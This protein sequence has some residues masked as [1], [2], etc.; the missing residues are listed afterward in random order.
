MATEAGLSAAQVVKSGWYKSLARF[1]HPN[2]RQAVWQMVNSFVPYLGLW[3][4][5]VV[6]VQ[7]GQGWLWFLPLL[8]LAAAGWQLRLFIIFH[9]C[10]HSSFFGSA[11]A[12]RIVG[13]VTGIVNFTPFEDWRH[14]HLVHHA[15][16][17]D[18]DLRGTGDVWTMTVAEYQ[19]AP[20][21]KR[22]AYRLFRT[23]FV[24]FV[25]GPTVVFMLLQRFPRKGIS[26]RE[27]FSVL[28]TDAAVL[29]MAAVLS[30]TLG[31]RTY[32]LIQVPLV[33]LAAGAGVWFFYVQHQFEGVYWARHASWDPIRAA[34]EGASYYRLPKV[35]QWFSGN[36][37]LHHIHH[38]RPRIPNYSLQPC[39]DAT[40]ALQQ[41]KPLTFRAS[42]HSLVLN[43]WD[44]SNQRLVSF[45]T[46]RSL[47][48]PTGAGRG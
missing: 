41:I 32:L 48:R 39:Q 6:V 14:S 43:L 30:A 19:A 23:P 45:G 18:L 46:L 16:V 8:L 13:Y 10:V 27:R 44:E 20:R 42:L 9:D 34:L 21:L 26:P 1:Q 35:L 5:M 2:V 33:V 17:A 25:L 37:G 7:A 31:L 47:S 38:L 3:A 24:L 29:A 40:A 11:R 28:F 12:N 4:L 15:T 36:I 22:L